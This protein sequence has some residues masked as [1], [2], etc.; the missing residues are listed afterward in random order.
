[1]LGLCRGDTESVLS[2]NMISN[3]HL[4]DSVGFISSMQRASLFFGLVL[5]SLKKMWSFL[6]EQNLITFLALIPDLT[7]EDEMLTMTGKAVKSSFL[8]FTHLTTISGLSPLGNWVPLI[9]PMSSVTRLIVIMVSNDNTSV[10]PA[11]ACMPALPFSEC[12]WEN[13]F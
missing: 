4:C 3:D 11:L 12:T 10:S 9:L 5:W 6:R 13:V 8:L 1:M 2:L 7:R